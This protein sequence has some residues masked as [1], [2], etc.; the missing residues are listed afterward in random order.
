[1]FE[2]TVRFRH[3]KS[4]QSDGYHAATAVAAVSTVWNRELGLL[5]ITKFLPL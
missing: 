1:M 4:V 5:F 2:T 3:L